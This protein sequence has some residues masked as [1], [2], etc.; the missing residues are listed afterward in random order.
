M[1]T[2][3]FTE[4]QSERE[5][6]AR[7]PIMESQEPV[8]IQQSGNHKCVWEKEEKQTHPTLVSY[9]CTEPRCGRG[10]LIDEKVD[11]ITNY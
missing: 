2:Q 4:K 9:I 1:S 7:K 11:S 8:V 10:K 5:G 6:L 3:K